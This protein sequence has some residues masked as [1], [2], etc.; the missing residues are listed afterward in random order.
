MS[1]KPRL[2][3]YSATCV[4]SESSSFP[5]MLETCV[6]TVRSL[7][8]SSPPISLLDRSVGDQEQHFALARGEV[9]VALVLFA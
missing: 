1:A 6:L 8:F 2:W 5:K 7:I 4:R 3:A 9:V